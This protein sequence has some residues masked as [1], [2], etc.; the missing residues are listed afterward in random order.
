MGNGF[1]GSEEWDFWVPLFGGCLFGEIPKYDKNDH[2]VPVIGDESI[3]YRP[4]WLYSPGIHKPVFVVMDY[5][6]SS[7]SLEFNIDAAILKGQ[8][9]IFSQHGIWRFWD[10]PPP[11]I[12]RPETKK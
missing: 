11:E 2:E 1:V 10:T 3:L 12:A 9:A 4:L 7:L 5:Y 6:V 8:A